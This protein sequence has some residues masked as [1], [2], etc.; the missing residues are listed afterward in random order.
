LHFQLESGPG[1]LRGTVKSSGE[2][3]AGAPVYL[4]G[5]DSN[6]KQRVGALRTAWTDAR[7]GFRFDALAPGSYRVLATF[8]Y[9]DPDVETMDANA[10]EITVAPHA[11]KPVDVELYVI[12]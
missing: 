6:G 3:V 5:W 10:Q 11:E 2:P 4:E 9:I 12:R 1:S 7:G 8:E